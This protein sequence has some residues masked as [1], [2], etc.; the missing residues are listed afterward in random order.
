[1]TIEFLRVWEDGFQSGGLNCL[2]EVDLIALSLKLGL[3][4]FHLC[5]EGEESFMHLIHL[6]KKLKRGLQRVAK[7]IK[8]RQTWTP[9]P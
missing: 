1:L 4:L 7:R 3:L 8:K 9:E 2:K 5:P 6:L